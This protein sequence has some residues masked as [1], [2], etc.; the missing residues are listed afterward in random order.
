MSHATEAMREAINIAERL[1]EG[2]VWSVMVT[3]DTDC[4]NSAA[5]NIYVTDDEQ[6]GRIRRTLGLQQPDF[7]SDDAEQH[8][9]YP[10][11]RITISIIEHKES[12]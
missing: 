11:Q 5:F 6:R 3:H 9:N 8:D 2:S 7:E 1:P 12:K 10:P 4:E